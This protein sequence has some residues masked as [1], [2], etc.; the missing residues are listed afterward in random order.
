ML[1]VG[2]NIIN[3]NS[4]Q[5]R[6]DK[7]IHINKLISIL[8][9][10]SGFLIV[11]AWDGCFNMQVLFPIMIIVIL[12]YLYKINGVLVV[13]KQFKFLFLISLIYFISLLTN[14][15]ISIEILSFTSIIRIIYSIL[16]LLYY[17]IIVSLNID[18]DNLKI[19]IIGNILSGVFIAILIIVNWIGGADG[20]IS[21]VSLFGDS[22]EEN[23]TGAILAFEFVLCLILMVFSKKYYQKI[24][25]LLFDFIMV[26]S[27][28]L[29]GS[30]AAIIAIVLAVV[31]FLLIYVF[32]LKTRIYKKVLFIIFVFACFFIIYTKA[33]T[34]LPDFL[35]NRMFGNLLNGLNDRSNTERLA[36]WNYGIENFVKRILFGYGVGNFNYYVRQIWPQ[37]TVVVAHNTFLDF[38]LDSGLV[39]CSLI[40]IMLFQNIK[41]LFSKRGVVF[42]PLLL[43]LVITSFIVGGERTY[44]F[45]NGFIILSLL[46]KQICK[47]IR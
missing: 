23:Y 29:T 37:H 21:L 40:L 10:F 8:I 43:C 18:I 20:K 31:F 33:E 42:L 32:K 7:Y 35:Y 38:L 17:S 34:I 30:R 47:Q 12:W 41:G 13:T 26:F 5:S 25:Y 9:G 14:F 28:F 22:V 19:V 1:R 15:I 27:V 16:I 44:F 39:G 2:D 45:W 36:L 24:I 11:F 6:K 46:C 4:L 3:V